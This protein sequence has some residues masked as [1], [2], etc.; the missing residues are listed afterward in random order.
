M[1]HPTINNIVTVGTNKRLY[2]VDIVGAWSENDS[3]IAQN[4]YKSVLF[5]LRFFLVDA[6]NV[7]LEVSDGVQTTFDLTIANG[8]SYL[9]DPAGH[10]LIFVNG[11]LQPPGA[12]NAYNA[13]SDK[14][15]FS[16]PPDIGSTFTGFYVGKLRQLDDISFE[17]DSLRQSFNLKRDDVFY[18]LTLTEGVQIQQ[19]HQRIISSFL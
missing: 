14:I 5:S 4:D 13:F 3:V 12:G 18:S 11:I 2:L 1:L 6:Q 19:L 9:P 8:T 15:Q 17:F 10:M 16:E 7:H